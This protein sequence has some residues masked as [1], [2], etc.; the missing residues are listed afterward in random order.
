MHAFLYKQHFSKQRQAKIGKNQ[1]KPTQHPETE[2]LLLGNYSLS[3]PTLS[4]RNN[5]RYSQKYKKASTSVLLRLKAKSRSYR[6]DINRP[7]PSHG[8]K[9]CVKCPNTELFLVRI[10]P[11]SD[12][13]RWDTKYLS[14]FSLNEGKYGP[15]ITPYLDTFHAVKYTNYIICLGI[16][17]AI[18]IKQH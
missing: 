10:F 13:I 11:H 7:R 17:M 18:C 1:A 6:Y 15:E 8:H 3:S 4:S 14:V 16:V 9:H 12:W 2:L 5:R